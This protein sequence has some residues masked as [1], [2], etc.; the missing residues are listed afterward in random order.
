MLNT[1]TKASFHS[2]VI[3]RLSLSRLLMYIRYRTETR[4]SGCS[5]GHASCGDK[6]VFRS[7][8]THSHREAGRYKATLKTRKLYDSCINMWLGNERT[9]YGPFILN[10][11]ICGCIRT[12]LHNARF[13]RTSCKP[14][15]P[16][17]QTWK[18]TG[19]RFVYV[20]SSKF[21]EKLI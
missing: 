9:Y 14:V 12:S 11:Q 17:M 19:G 13:C 5:A 4:P 2:H 16:F 10:I 3:A 7:G 6:Q 20:F 1:L 15:K 8:P 21:W 18:M